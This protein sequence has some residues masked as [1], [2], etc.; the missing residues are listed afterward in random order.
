MYIHSVLNKMFHQIH[1][2]IS[3]KKNILLK[4]DI[5]VKD[6]KVEAFIV[7][8]VMIS[9]RCVSPSRIDPGGYHFF[10]FII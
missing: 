3:R 1:T 5:H 4:D 6:I 9:C 2:I 7:L 8:M 10:T